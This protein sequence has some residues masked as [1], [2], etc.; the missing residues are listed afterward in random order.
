LPV[1]ELATVFLTDH[2]LGSTQ[3]NDKF[4]FLPALI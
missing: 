4:G 3:E 2:G 1:S